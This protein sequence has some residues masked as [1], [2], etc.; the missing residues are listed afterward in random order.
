MGPSAGSLQTH[1]GVSLGVIEPPLLPEGCSATRP[2]L[3]GRVPAGGKPWGWAVIRTQP[4]CPCTTNTTHED[5]QPTL[6]TG[7]SDDFYHLL[8]LSAGFSLRFQ[9]LLYRQLHT[10]ALPGR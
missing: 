2:V 1:A 9:I 7:S 8:T 3:V 6:S 10:T 4:C 5:S